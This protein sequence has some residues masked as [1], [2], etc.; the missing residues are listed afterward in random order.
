MRDYTLANDA[1]EYAKT[2]S[3]QLALAAAQRAGATDPHVETSVMERRAHAGAADEYLA[4]ATVR[5]RATG[6]PMTG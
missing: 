1:I 6:R 5:S 3:Q 4:E 2:V